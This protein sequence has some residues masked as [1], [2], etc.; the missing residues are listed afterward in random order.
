VT[1][2][3]RRPELVF[4]PIKTSLRVKMADVADDG[5]SSDG[6]FDGFNEEEIRQAEA[7]NEWDFEELSSDEEL[8]DIACLDTDSGGESDLADSED[9]DWELALPNSP[10]NNNINP[11]IEF[12]EVPGP[13]RVPRT[14]TKPIDFFF[15]FFSWRLMDLICRQTNLYADQQ[16]A[17]YTERQTQGQRRS[18]SFERTWRWWSGSG[19]MTFARLKA[20][21]GKHFIANFVFVSFIKFASVLDMLDLTLGPLT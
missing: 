9:D 6:S 3:S 10:V 21:L 14:A 17:A 8:D 11:E 19:Q 12:S 4:A 16:Q 13:Q 5:S 1:Y 2:L 18:A 15:L 20:F 7:R